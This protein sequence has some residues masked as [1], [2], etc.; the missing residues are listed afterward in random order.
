MTTIAYPADVLDQDQPSRLR[1]AVADTLAVT[2]RNLR[3][4]LRTPQLLVFSSIQPIIF[5][6][7]FRY[8]FGGAIKVT[9]FRYVD[10]LMPGIFAQTITFGA[11]NTGVGLAEDLNKGLIDRFRSLPM[12]RSA[13]LIGRTVADIARNVFVITLMVML[14]VLSFWPDLA[15]WLPRMAA[16]K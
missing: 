11:I 6:L 1:R 16:D 2:G 10:F 8:V 3:G 14:A 4:Y 13:V 7:L 5:V 12:A 15:L 9:G